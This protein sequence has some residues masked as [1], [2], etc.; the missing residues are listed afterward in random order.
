ML[1]WTKKAVFYHIYPLGFCGAPFENIN[2][3]GIENRICK[4]LE[5]IPHLKELGVNAIYFGPLFES[6]THGYDTTDYYHIDK[7]LGSNE[8][9]EAVCMKLHEADIKVVVDGVFNHVGRDFFAF[10]DLQEKGGYSKY[11]DWFCNVNFEEKSP[12]GD[13]F[14]YEAWEGHF[15]LVKLN[16]WNEELKGHLLNA[17]GE[18]IDRYQI[19][20]L[21]LDVAYSLDENFMRA[22]RGFVKQKRE[23]FWLMGE[24]IHGDHN[25]LIKPDLLESTT[26]Y[27]CYAGIYSSHNEKNYFEI[28]HSLNRLF[29][30]DGLYKGFDLYNFVDN[31]DVERLGSILSDKRHLENCYTLLFTMPGIPSVYYGS[32]WG[33]EGK[34]QEGSDYELRPDLNLDEMLNLDQKL[35]KHIYELSTIKQQY[36]A[37]SDG[38]Y[39]EVIVT[40]EQLLFART[41]DNSKI[42]VALN[43]ADAEAVLRMQGDEHVNLVNILGGEEGI[44][45]EDGNYVVQLPPFGAKILVQK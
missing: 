4:V 37:L 22:L 12:M 35:V 16:L 41:S 30:Q 15:E 1:N 39:E 25:R 42:Y 19:D 38:I 13:S 40:N 43:L 6:K 5:W 36:E 32:E 3:E 29:S 7:R 26:N 8:D 24:I 21:R 33:I 27:E 10:K 34:K 17:V 44:P 28:N 31:H 45:F 11:K 2:Q 18:W 9:F 23:D 14:S 20:G